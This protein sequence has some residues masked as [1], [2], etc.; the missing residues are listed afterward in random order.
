MLTRDGDRITT[1]RSYAVPFILFI[2]FKKPTVDKSFISNF[3]MIWELLVVDKERQL[4]NS[5]TNMYM[6]KESSDTKS[7]HKTLI[8]SG[9]ISFSNFSFDLVNLLLMFEFLAAE[10]FRRRI[11]DL[12]I[13]SITTNRSGSVC[14]SSI[15]K[16]ALSLCY[17]LKYK[18]TSSSYT[19]N[20]QETIDGKT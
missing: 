19:I 12:S 8:T 6:I 15:G 13:F 17:I 2:I 1:N 7:I 10:V 14:I 9:I 3:K 11:I 20:L 5:L 18:T 16:Q 4:V